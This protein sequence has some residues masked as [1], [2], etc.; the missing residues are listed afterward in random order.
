MPPEPGATASAPRFPQVR[1]TDLTPGRSPTET[2][3]V[4]QRRLRLAIRRLRLDAGMTQRQVAGELRWSESKVGRMESGA[5][6]VAYAALLALLEL[7]GAEPADA[8]KLTT[9]AR[10]SRRRAWFDAY[11]QDLDPQSFL[12]LGY[13]ESAIRIRECQ[14]IVVPVPLRSD[15]YARCLIEALHLGD[16]AKQE[17]I[18]EIERIRR[19]SWLSTLGRRRTEVVLDESVLWRQI[20]GQRIMR[21]QLDRLR[22]FAYDHCDNV[23]IRV[24]PLDVDGYVGLSSSFRIFDF[25]DPADTPVSSIEDPVINAVSYAEIYEST[26]DINEHISR[27]E[28]AANFALSADE[29]RRL[30]DQRVAGA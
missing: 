27:F 21:D 22:K 9:F 5:T 17:R 30:L 8:A 10:E 20:G 23:I 7:Y 6:T 26:D 11:R 24:I 18:V 19:E 28:E 12:L 15:E 1:G 16:L 14:S 29:T 13:E 4:L 2:P 3:A 25:A